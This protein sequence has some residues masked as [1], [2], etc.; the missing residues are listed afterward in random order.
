MTHPEI[1][2]AVEWIDAHA[3]AADGNVA[4]AQ[5]G[6]G[7]RPLACTDEQLRNGP[8]FRRSARGLRRQ[9]CRHCQQPRPSRRIQCSESE[10]QLGEL[11]VLAQEIRHIGT[12][13]T[14]ASFSIDGAATTRGIFGTPQA[15]QPRWPS[16][17]D[18]PEPPSPGG[19]P[20]PQPRPAPEQI[21]DAAQALVDAG[22]SPTVIAVRHRLGG[23]S[24]RTIESVLAHW[25]TEQ[26]GGAGLWKESR[27]ERAELLEEIARQDERIEVLLAVLGAS[28]QALAEERDGSRTGPGPASA[29]VRV[30]RP[31]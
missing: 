3:R 24:P 27:R 19:N 30:S 22:R 16:R 12:P 10:H 15:S 18:D 8:L 23:G 1:D 29:S 2:P 25:L 20:M 6:Q 14:S 17:R 11:I 31:R 21:R 13:R 7:P 28:E 9:L 26:Q 5:T 4:T